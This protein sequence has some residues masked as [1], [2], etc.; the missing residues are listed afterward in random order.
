MNKNKNKNKQ[1]YLKALAIFRR[2]YL[3][4]QD[5]PRGHGLGWAGLPCSH[6]WK[7]PGPAISGSGQAH[8]GSPAWLS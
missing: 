6:A 2:R 1:R 8:S 7:D 4:P 3:P 5:D